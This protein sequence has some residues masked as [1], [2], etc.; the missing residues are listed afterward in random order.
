MRISSREAVLAWATGLVAL[1]GLT[2]MFCEPRVREIGAVRDEAAK[3]AEKI[4]LDERLT[5]QSQSWK[6]KLGE[7]SRKLP[8]FPLDRDVTADMLITLEKTA[9][10]QGISL[11]RREADQEKKQGEVYELAI[12]CKWE[13][14]L[15]ALVRFLFQLQQQG[16]TMDMGQLSVTPEKALLKGGFTLDCVYRKAPQGAGS[17]PRPSPVKENVVPPAIGPGVSPQGRGA[18]PSQ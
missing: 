10:E 4:Q 9:K 13:G 1:G 17:A 14:N 15:E 7:I 8:S 6:D 12:S 18:G 3:I 11:P 5:A 16:A 2:Y